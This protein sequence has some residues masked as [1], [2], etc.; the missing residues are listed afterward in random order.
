MRPDALMTI[1]DRWLAVQGPQ[2]WWPAN[3]PF[4]VLVGAILT[5]NTSWKNVERAIANLKDAGVL[6]PLA[7]WNL[8]VQRLAQLLQP[9]G[10]YNVKAARLRNAVHFLLDKCNGD[11]TRLV[12]TDTDTF[13]SFLLAISGI[14]LEIADSILLYALQR[15]VF[16]VDAYTRRIFGRMGLVDATADYETLRHHFETRLPRDVSLYNDY[17]AQVVAHAKSSCRVRPVCS[18]CVVCD[19]CRDGR[20]TNT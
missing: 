15:L 19:L 11:M 8:P 16:V 3:T 12:D 1:Y 9:A 18:G 14:G 10:Y 2:H 20:M 7:L 13:R 4:E 6:K 17:H 5:Q